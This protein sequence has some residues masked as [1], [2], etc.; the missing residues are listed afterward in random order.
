M[1]LLIIL[2][3]LLFISL[4]SINTYFK[5]FLSSLKLNNTNV[6]NTYIYFNL[7]PLKQ[8]KHL[9]IGLSNISYYQ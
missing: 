1:V 3:F 2:F 7:D 8:Q 4:I 5:A 9:S 6:L